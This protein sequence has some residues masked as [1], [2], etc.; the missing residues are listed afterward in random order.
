MRSNVGTGWS[1]STGSTCP[2]KEDALRRFL[3]G[4]RSSH[5]FLIV[6]ALF[7]IDLVIPDPVP[8]LDEAFLGVVTLLLARWKRS[9]DPQ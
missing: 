6:A 3:S 2:E 9:S 4:L 1:I 8:F 7:L 5:L